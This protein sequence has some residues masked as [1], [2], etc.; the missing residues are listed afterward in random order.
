MWTKKRLNFKLDFLLWCIPSIELTNDMI[1]WVSL[2]S[3][4]ASPFS[5]KGLNYFGTMPEIQVHAP[6]FRW[7]E[8]DKFT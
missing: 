1:E 4:L 5:Q 7:L 6:Y 2:F 3:M 8:I